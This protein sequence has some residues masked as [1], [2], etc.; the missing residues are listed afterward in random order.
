M[1]ATFAVKQYPHFVE[2]Q[3]RRNSILYLKRTFH[4][5]NSVSVPVESISY[6]WFN[7]RRK[8]K[9]TERN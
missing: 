6:N 2:K 4:H 8:H 7:L 5:L 1:R 3:L 9:N